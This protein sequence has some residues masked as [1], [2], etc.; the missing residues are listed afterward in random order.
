MGKALII[1][2]VN[3]QSRNFGQVHLSR[4]L[5]IIGDDIISQ[6]TVFKAYYNG[7]ESSVQWSITGNG[8]I[9]SASGSSTTV[10]PLD[11]GSVLVLTA[12][13]NEESTSKTITVNQGTIETITYL[14]SSGAQKINTDYY[15]NSKTVI[16]FRFKYNDASTRQQ[17]VVSNE[18]SGAATKNYAFYLN[19]NGANAIQHG[20]STGLTFQVGST[21]YTYIVHIDS[22][23]KIATST[24]VDNGS[25]STQSSLPTLETSSTTLSLFGNGTNYAYIDMN[26]LKIWEDDVLLHDYEPRIKNNVYG[27]LDVVTGIFYGSATETP[28]SGG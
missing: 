14:R 24:R 7:E 6:P 12:T 15:P 13:H 20:S 5:R 27:M 18:P 19:G 22:S 17:R 9:S 10:T 2:G 4:G 16:E 26:Y 23:T 3:W 28:F 21:A 1:P 25:V 8:T 11:D